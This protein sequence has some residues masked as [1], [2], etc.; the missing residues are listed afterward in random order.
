MCFRFRSPCPRRFLLSRLLDSSF[1]H[2]DGCFL[3]LMFLGSL[4]HSHCAQRSSQSLSTQLA[5]NQSH[6]LAS[7]SVS[8]GIIIAFAFTLEILYHVGVKL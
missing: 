7:R 4:L 3:F 2:S 8:Q 5:S 6:Q 1:S